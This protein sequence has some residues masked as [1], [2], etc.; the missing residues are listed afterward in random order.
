M[1]KNNSNTNNDH[2]QPQTKLYHSVTNFEYNN[3]QATSSKTNKQQQQQQQQ[4]QETNKGE[5][6]I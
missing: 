2:Q 3:E 1:D 6:P 5:T 4:Q